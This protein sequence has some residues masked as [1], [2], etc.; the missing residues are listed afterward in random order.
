MVLE[1]FLDEWHNDN[2]GACAY[3]WFYGQAETDVGGE[4]EDA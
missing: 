1:E 4:A 2:P 3:E